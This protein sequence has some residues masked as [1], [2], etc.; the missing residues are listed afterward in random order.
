LPKSHNLTRNAALLI[1]GKA[2]AFAAT[3]A[4]PLIIVRRLSPFQVG[5]YQQV[6]L[7][8]NTLVTLLPLSVSL[9]AYYF[10]PREPERAPQVVLNICLYSLGVGALA[11]ALL[12]AAPGLVARILA[13]PEL[14]GYSHWIGLAATL[15]LLGAALEPVSVARE[16]IKTAT[17]F[18]VG[19]SVARGTLMTGAALFFSTVP[20]LVW[21]IVIFAAAQS[22]VT[23]LYFHS[24]YPRLWR[25]FDGSMA[26]R[27]LRYAA[28]LGFSGILWYSQTD[29]HNYFVSHIAGT[30]A[31]AAY[32]YGTFDIPLAG[33][34][35][36]GVATVLIPRLSYLQKA[37]DHRAIV[38]IL[39]AA[40]RKLAFL[41]FPIAGVL[42]VTS[43]EFILFLFTPRF[44]ASIPIFRINLCLLPLAA[45]LIDPVIR[46]YTQFHST[47]VR[48]RIVTFTALC[49]ALW[50]FTSRFGGL[51]AIS[52][53]VSARYLETVIVALLLWPI[54]G[55]RPTDIRLL[56]DPAKLAAAAVFAAAVTEL[57]RL[58]L[59]GSRPFDIL[60][61]CG[62][63][64]LIAYLT[65]VVALRV[66]TIEEW[67]MARNLLRKTATRLRLGSPAAG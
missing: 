13:D 20:A 9:S 14:A 25:A 48:L 55:I 17:A 60:A 41:I 19:S 31:F 26:L 24:K 47:L 1:V 51:G 16:D 61:V 57:A 46:A 50:F 7:V 40:M 39:G 8:I 5:T 62:T 22:A 34:V 65:A 28:P 52:V 27:Q 29:L 6:F 12:A 10:L 3:F 53:V 58:S 23:L 15:L 11:W 43:R 64:Y 21:A 37:G 66:P 59:A 4:V 44:A 35:T 33:I 38:E 45:V 49:A 36:E 67:A 32:S 63:V 2:L 54:V 18:I 42:L 56:R 30:I